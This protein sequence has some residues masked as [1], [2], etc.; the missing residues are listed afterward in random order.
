MGT[1]IHIVLGDVLGDKNVLQNLN[2]IEQ[3]KLTHESFTFSSVP[4]SIAVSQNYGL[5]SWLANVR[6]SV[7]PIDNVELN[8]KSTRQFFDWYDKDYNSEYDATGFYTYER[9]LDRLNLG[10]HTRVMYTLDFLT[11]F[12]YDA[13]VVFDNDDHAERGTYRDIFPAWF[14]QLIDYCNKTGYSFILF[15]FDS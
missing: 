15:G 7:K 9:L 5:F 8:I 1:T 14:F 2:Q 10:D 4:D 6:G 11:S 12:D 3:S 13:E